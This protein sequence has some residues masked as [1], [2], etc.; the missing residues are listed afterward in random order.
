MQE[1]R[2]RPS[3]QK[4]GDVVHLRAS[5]LGGCET[6]LVW[7]IRNGLSETP[8][9]PFVREAMDDSSSLEEQAFQL[10]CDR[11]HLDATE[12]ME[13]C[14]GETWINGWT[15][16]GGTDREHPD[17]NA[18][19]EIKCMSEKASED[20]K[21]QFD[22]PWEKRTGLALKYSWQLA[23]YERIHR[24][25]E[26]KYWFC[27][28]EKK[29]GSLTGELWTKLLQPVYDYPTHSH[30]VAKINRLQE[31]EPVRCTS[32]DS[33]WCPYSE[34]HDDL[35]VLDIDLEL[36]LISVLK[37]KKAAAESELKEVQA[38][39]AEQVQAEGGKAR[40]TNGTKLTWVEAEV[41]EKK[42]R[43]YTRRYLKITPRKDVD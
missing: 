19:V 23:A 33:S 29:N 10:M 25:D 36:N 16:T 31:A 30:L 2:E 41:K 37:Q 34:C 1:G 12:W 9:P 18:I 24:P 8:P 32:F 13:S 14:P 4:N 27:V 17:D 3:V 26:E 43:E 22:L 5:A 40:S 15:I 20:L 28:A 35:P 11:Q 42:P 7:A 21:K 39:V 6:G 38:R